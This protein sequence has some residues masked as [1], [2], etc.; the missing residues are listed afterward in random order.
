MYEKILIP[1]DGSECSFKA[2]EHAALIASQNNA[3]IIVLNVL[4]IHS[5]AGLPVEEFA[6]KVNEFFKIESGKT[7][8]MTSNKI[9]DYI[10]KNKLNEVKI[11]T[12][13]LEGSP[14]DMILQTVDE[15]NIDLIVM[16]AS[17]KHGVERFLLGSVTEKVVRHAHCPV[18]TVH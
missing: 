9:K 16:G 5:L 7:L 18:L 14:A 15:E 17:G 10:V 1:S 4:E 13:K 8:V 11:T 2:S 3:E 12:N 6:H